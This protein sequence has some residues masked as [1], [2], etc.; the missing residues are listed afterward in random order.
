[1][2]GPEVAALEAQ[3]KELSALVG[4]LTDEEWD[5]PSRCDGWTVKELVAHCEGML[6]RLVGAN[7]EEVEGA[8]EIDRVGYYGYDP[9]GP[10]EG[11]DPK[12]TFSEVIRDRVVDEVGGRTGEELR[13]SLDAAIGAALEG[14]RK[15][16]ADRVI[17]RSGHPRMRF[18]EF[19]ASRVLEF[20][21][22]S[23]DLSHATLRGERIHPDA[24][25]IVKGI[26][27]G[28]LGAELP[29]GLGWDT[30]TFI[31]SGTGRRRLESN[32]RFAL[33]PLAAMFPLLA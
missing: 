20:G 19:V 9:D 27:D 25:E 22:H 16:P 28:R 5:R 6:H 13:E 21:V 1:M 4:E 8:P 10:R 2:Q 26:L 30:R 15:I 32:E 18:D 14:V 31:L 11:E 3:C 17:K 23:M 12:K 24:A 7:A 33:G 29:K